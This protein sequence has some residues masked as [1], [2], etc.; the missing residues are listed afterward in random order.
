M[1]G[2]KKMKVPFM[3][4]LSFSRK[5]LAEIARN[6]VNDEQILAKVLKREASKFSVTDFKYFNFVNDDNK[7]YRVIFQVLMKDKEKLVKRL[8]TELKYAFDCSDI[9]IAYKQDF[10][11]GKYHLKNG[12]ARGEIN[13]YSKPNNSYLDDVPTSKISPLSEID[14]KVNPP[15]NDL[16]Y[17]VASASNHEFISNTLETILNQN[18]NQNGFVNGNKKVENVI[19]NN[20]SQD[21]WQN[22]QNQNFDKLEKEDLNQFVPN[23]T[24]YNSFNNQPFTNNSKQ[25]T[26]NNNN[27]NLV[28][29]ESF[30]HN[31]LENN[32]QSKPDFLDHKQ[33]INTNASNYSNF[34]SNFQ[35]NKFNNQSDI[36]ENKEIVSEKN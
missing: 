36:F 20:L 10:D 14:K 8:F 9:E 17:T 35:N 11:F 27:I 25:N 28:K 13:T 34:T 24:D 32:N 23:H 4:V 7:V 12:L 6:T 18:Q 26:F 31:S 3:V 29:N 21:N 19:N 30:N 2:K 16:N 33:D 15:V 5:S 22:N 1:F